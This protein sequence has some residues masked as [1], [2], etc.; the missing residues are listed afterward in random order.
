M[1]L[2][3]HPLHALETYIHAHQ[4]AGDLKLVDTDE[5]SKANEH[6]L[7][8]LDRLSRASKAVRK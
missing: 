5:V 6:C 7:K 4:Q 8:V 2:F 3:P 1:M